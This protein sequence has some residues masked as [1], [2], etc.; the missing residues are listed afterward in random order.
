V[1]IIKPNCIAKRAVVLKVFFIIPFVLLSDEDYSKQSNLN[2]DT[3]K[4]AIKISVISDHGIIEICIF[5]VR[6]RLY[7]TVVW[8]YLQR[9]NCFLKKHLDQQWH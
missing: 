7:Q 4:I 9:D 3:G 8:Y 6:M 5:Y 2:T 1:T